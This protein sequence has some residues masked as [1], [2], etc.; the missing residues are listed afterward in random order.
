VRC[1]E[2]ATVVAVEILLEEDIVLEVRIACEL[3]MIFQHGT[4]VVHALE[5]EP[6]KAASS[7]SATSLIVL[8]R[9]EP[10]GHSTL[11]SSP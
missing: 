9:P 8:N 6:R 10:V 4:L 5:N 3:G 2:A 7:S 1:A 11:K